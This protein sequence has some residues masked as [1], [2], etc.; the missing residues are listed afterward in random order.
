MYMRNWKVVEGRKSVSIFLAMV[1][2]VGMC[3]PITVQAERASAAHGE[4]PVLTSSYSTVSGGDASGS[5]LEKI[6][7]S[8]GIMMRTQRLCLSAERMS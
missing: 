2:V 1:M 5:G 4:R 7:K 8:H 6:K 3:M